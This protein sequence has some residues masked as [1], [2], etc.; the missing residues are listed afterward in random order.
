MDVPHE[1]GGSRLIV[2]PAPLYSLNAIKKAAYRCM[3]RVTVDIDVREDEV[4]CTLQFPPDASPEHIAQADTA[5]RREVLDQ[6]LR[7]SIAAETTAYRDA[8]LALAFA[9]SDLAK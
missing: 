1:G 4:R 7:E 9:P 5:F 8:I 2:F 3:D 6:D